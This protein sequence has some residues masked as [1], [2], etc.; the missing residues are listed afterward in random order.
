MSK[1]FRLQV[2]QCGRCVLDKQVSDLHWYGT[3]TAT[4]PAADARQVHRITFK[5]LG[6]KKVEIRGENLFSVS[7]EVN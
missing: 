3:P 2:W 7:A 6:D 4:S 5:L 1:I